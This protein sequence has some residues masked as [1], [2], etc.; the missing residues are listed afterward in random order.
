VL[1]NNVF[2]LC[3]DDDDDGALSLGHSLAF[4][5]VY[6]GMLM[7]FLEWYGLFTLL[8]SF[9]IQIRLFWPMLDREYKDIH[10][11]P[12]FHHNCYAFKVIL[13]WF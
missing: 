8:L 12:S 10:P 1:W 4:V 13:Q 6:F 11:Y 7:F 9:V 2:W 3:F 5:E